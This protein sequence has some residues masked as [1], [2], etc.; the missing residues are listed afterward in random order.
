METSLDMSGKP[1]NHVLPDP[2][3]IAVGAYAAALHRS[4]STPIEALRRAALALPR[5][6]QPPQSRYV[7]VEGRLRPLIHGGAR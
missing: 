6:M 3:L 2:H 4:G 1:V 5:P 7:W